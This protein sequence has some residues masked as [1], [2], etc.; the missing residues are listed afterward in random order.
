MM[1]TLKS[2][3]T[4]GLVM[5]AL[6]MNAGC[7]DN[8]NN[9]DNNDNTVRATRTATPAA[10]VR[11]ATPTQAAVNP[12]P[13]ATPGGGTTTQTVDFNVTSTAGVQGFKLTVNYPTAKGSF[14]GSADSVACTTTAGGSFVPNDKDNGTMTLIVGNATNLTF[15]IP[16]SC[17]FDAT[18][19]ITSSDITVSVDDVTQGGVSGDKTVLSVATTVS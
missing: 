1:R 6:A 14:Q 18:S 15:P 3:V 10:P 5:A 7:G 2:G 9:N 11:T 19:T 4:I 16:I 13:T 17:K 12:T 8:D